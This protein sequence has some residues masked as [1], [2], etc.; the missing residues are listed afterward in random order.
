MSP[1]MACLSFTHESTR[2]QVHTYGIV[3][4]SDLRGLCAVADPT[5][6]RCPSCRGVE[7]LR[8]GRHCRARPR[9][10]RREVRARPMGAG[11][12]AVVV[13]LPRWGPML[14]PRVPNLVPIPGPR[15]ERVTPGQRPR[16]NYGHPH[17]R[18]AI[19]TR[20]VAQP[21][22]P[23][24]LRTRPHLAH[25]KAHPLPL[26]GLHPHDHL[27][28]LDANPRDLHAIR[29]QQH[30]RTSAVSANVCAVD[31][32]V[33]CFVGGVVVAPADVAADDGCLFC[34]GGV[35]GAVDAEVAQGLEVGFDAVEP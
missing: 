20:G 27:A 7:D 6:D 10:D 9:C 34:V 30:H 4:V 8:F 3:S 13:D 26:R 29:V 33:E 12:S 14:S 28:A 22:L 5:D 35:V 31:D 18:D 21:H 2:L 32:F 19:G 24:A 11:I 23:A 1:V 15:M 17:A 25:P 16:P